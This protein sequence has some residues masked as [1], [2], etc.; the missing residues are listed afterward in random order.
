MNGEAGQTSSPDEAA[1]RAVVDR[2]TKAFN[3][4]DARAIARLHTPD[5]R[6]IDLAG[7]VVEG[8]EA[9]EREYAG[10]FHDNPGATIEIKV[11]EL[12]LVGPDAAVEEGTT[13]VIPKDGA[14]RSSTVTRRSTSS[15]TASGFSPASASRRAR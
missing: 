5:A 3:A 4:G 6:V 14:P 8:R 10:L 2:F 12:R 13:R 15:A 7:E 1:I 11:D 9:I